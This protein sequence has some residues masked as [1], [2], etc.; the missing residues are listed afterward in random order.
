HAR[1]IAPGGTVVV[2]GEPDAP[3]VPLLA[4]RPLVGGLPAAYVCRGFVC[5][6]PVTTPEELTANLV[7]RP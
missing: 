1:R 3:G 7:L 4:D 5:D 2:P 6:R